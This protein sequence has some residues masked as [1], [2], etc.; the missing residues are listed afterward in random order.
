MA[1]TRPEVELA[2]EALLD[3]FLALTDSRDDDELVDIEPAFRDVAQRWEIQTDWEAVAPV[4]VGELKRRHRA[5]R[6]ALAAG[7]MYRDRP[8]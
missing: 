4:R 8:A 2:T 7:V 6:A 1:A 3:A 5:A